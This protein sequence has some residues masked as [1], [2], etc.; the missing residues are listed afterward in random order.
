MAL[1]KKKTN[2]KNKGQTKKNKTT[3]KLVEWWN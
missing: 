3:K 1:I 2:Q